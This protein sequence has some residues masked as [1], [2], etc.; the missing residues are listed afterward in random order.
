MGNLLASF[1]PAFKIYE[2]V[3]FFYRKNRPIH[4]QNGSQEYLRCF[5]SSMHFLSFRM[6]KT[7]MLC[8]SIKTDRALTPPAYLGGPQ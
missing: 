6:D 2:T 7:D 4:R 8:Y 1:T 5:G 3:R